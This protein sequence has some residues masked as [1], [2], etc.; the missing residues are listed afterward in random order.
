MWILGLGPVN[1]LKEGQKR[2]RP[3]IASKSSII[4]LTG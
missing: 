3:K 1:C 4:P 2:G